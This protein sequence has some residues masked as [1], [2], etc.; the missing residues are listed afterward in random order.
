MLMGFDLAPRKCGWCAGTGEVVPTAGGFRLPGL[1]AD[2][3]YLMDA[4]KERVEPLL[5]LY[6]PTQ[7]IYES[8]ILPA[9]PR[10]KASVM[11]SLEQRRAQFGQGAFFEWLCRQ[12]SI[13]CVEASVWDV[14]QALTGSKGADKDQMVAA[15]LRLGVRL[16][17]LMV[18]GR[19]DAAD[20]VGAWLVGVRHY[21]KQ[22]LPDWD[23]RV[24]SRRGALL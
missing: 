10:F 14:K 17:D 11:G 22:Y 24:H 1:D 23:R 19:E 2:L 15:A 9:G 18:E 4:L 20:A 3:G 21:A 7:V 13:P 5:D 8:P 6:R 16:P 12:R